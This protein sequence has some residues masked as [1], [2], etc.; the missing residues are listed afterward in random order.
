MRDVL[1]DLQTWRFWRWYLVH[2]FSAVGAL[3]VLLEVI[4]FVVPD[5]LPIDGWPLAAGIIVVAVVYG[6]V[7]AWPRPIEQNFDSPQTRIHILKGD[8]FSQ[9]CHL[10]IGTCDTFDTLVPNIISKK[11]IQGQALD[12]LH[13]GNVARLNEELTQVLAGRKVVGTIAKEGK[14]QKYGIGAIATLRHGPHNAYFLAYAEMNEHNEAHSTAD[15]IWKSLSLLWQEVSRTS[16]GGPVAIPVIGGG[17]SRVSQVVP[18]QDAIRL[19]VLSYMF[20]SRAK[21]VCDELRII[22]R[23]QD[24]DRLDRL[25]LQAFLNSM[26][27]S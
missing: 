23:P 14:T 27:S 26:R 19:I 15:G 3:V 25:Q 5:G 18:A 8:L 16:N 1:K 12:R 10:V 6:L 2:S 24:F 11:S 21:K 9:D 4:D 17:Q 22:V 20:A 13:G 7:R